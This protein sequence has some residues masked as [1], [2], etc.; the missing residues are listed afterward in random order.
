MRSPVSLLVLLLAGPL[1]GATANAQQWVGEQP[2]ARSP[3]F[4]LASSAAP[5]PVDARRVAALRRRISLDLPDATLD[6]AL[7]AISRQSGIHFMYSKD[8]VRLDDHVRLRAQ[9]ITVAAALTELLMDAN[10]DVVLSPGGQ[11]LLTRHVPPKEAR[12]QNGT[13]AGTVVDSATREP[14]AAVS[15]VVDGTRLGALTDDQGHYQIPNVPEGAHTVTARR[16]GYGKVTLSVTITGGAQATLDFALPRAASSLEQVVVTAT[17]TARKK[18]IGNSV[19][20]IDAEEIAHAPVTTPEQVIDGR[21]PGVSVLSNSGQPGSGGT[22]RLRGTG[23]VSQGNT[24]IIYIDGVRMYN[25]NAPTDAMSRQAISPLNDIDPADIDHVEIVKGPAATTLYGTEASG[26]VIQI[27]TKKGAAGKSR[28]TARVSQGINNLGHLGGDQNPTGFFLNECR[29]ADLVNG[30]GVRFEDP[31]CPASGSW[32]RDGYVSRYSLAT[33]GG[34]NAVT[35]YLSGAYDDESGVISTSRSKDAGFRGNFGFTPAPHLNLKAS[36]AYTRRDVSW[37]AD[38][39]NANGFLLNVSRGPSGSMKGGGCSDPAVVCVTN[40]DI[41][42]M[43]NATQ[44]DHFILGLDATHEA[45]GHLTNVLRLGYDYARARDKAVTP[46]GYLTLPSGRMFWREWDQR[47]LTLDYASTLN[48]TLGRSWSTATSVG[49]QMFNSWQTNTGIQGQNFAGPGDPTLESSSVRDLTSDLD[50]HVINAGFF[51]QEVLG[52]RDRLFLTGGLRVDGNSAF[53]SSFG[54]QAYPKVSAA[55]T[56]SDESFWPTSIAETMKLRAAYGESGK[57]P[58]AFDAVRTWAP[59][60][61]ENGQPAFTPDQIGNPDL[62]PERTREYELGFDATTIGGRVN[63]GLTYYHQHTLDALIP[64]EYPASE[65]FVNRQLE[66]VGEVFNKGLEVSVDAGIV[67]RPRFDWHVGVNYSGN[68]NRAGN[69]GGQSITISAISGEYVREGYAVPAY[70]GRVVTNPNDYADPVFAEDQYLG[71]IYPNKII[72][73]TTNLRFL[74]RF[75]LSALG[76]W[77]LG[78]HLLNTMG[79]SLADNMQI[80]PACYAAQHAMAAAADGDSSGLGSITALQ[81]A[82]CST[83]SKVKAYT[84]WVEPSDFFKLRSVSL[85]YN[86]PA[87]W[88]G[89]ARSGSVTLA[90]RNLFTATK[91]RGTDPEVNDQGDNQFARRDYYNLPPYRTFVATLTIDF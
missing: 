25:G 1:F 84:L 55:Y 78:G 59:V 80:W 34:T 17:G 9:E 54:L 45:F 64:V 18:E 19:S 15:V 77:Q 53:G 67:S 65:G 86:L 87:R 30:L 79:Y 90:G 5:V 74:E 11:A 57:A 49:A 7:A 69:L 4:L 12:V 36:T 56:I 63:I 33:S 76:E 35:Y 20:T 31:T 58:G 51:A 42:S 37:V 81:R 71:A 38:G 21:S 50:Q 10:V 8:V 24:P 72:G 2:A 40:G 22:I 88:L 39:D 82:Q 28:W 14:V 16:I 89:G 83:S 44:S 61:A 91:Y 68:T 47:L 62:G 48:Y 26:G 29:G 13:V 75:R 3:R 32:L 43:D 52:W 66:N 60:S 41:L 6:E 70:F 46:F 73:L 23:S 85:T 27:F